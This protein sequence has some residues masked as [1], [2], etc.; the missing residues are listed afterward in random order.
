MDFIFGILWLWAAC[1]LAKSHS[2]SVPG[3]MNHELVN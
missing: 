2:C 3:E 1:K